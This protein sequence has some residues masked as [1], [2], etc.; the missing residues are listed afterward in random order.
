MLETNG[1][2]Y[3]ELSLHNTLL[4]FWPLSLAIS[5]D[6]SPQIESCVSELLAAIV[7]TKYTM[8]NLSSKHLSSQMATQYGSHSID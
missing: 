8:D 6:N 1:T 2:S 4:V 3:I 7:H 5:H